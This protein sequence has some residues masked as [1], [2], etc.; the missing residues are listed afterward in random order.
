MSRPGIET[1]SPGPLANTLLIRPRVRLL[2]SLKS[3]NIFYIYS[4]MKFYTV[5]VMDDLYN[6]FLTKPT[7]INNYFEYSDH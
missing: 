5:Y 6:S 2:I 3:C 1:Y 4:E 7:L